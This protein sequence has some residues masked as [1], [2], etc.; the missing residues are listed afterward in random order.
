MLLYMTLNVLHYY[1]IPKEARH[2]VDSEEVVK[3]I[4]RKEYVV[5]GR[6]T[7]YVHLSIGARVELWW[8]R[9]ANEW[10]IRNATKSRMK[11]F[12]KYKEVK[13]G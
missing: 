6:F 5:D 7:Y 1:K 3:V 2:L 9:D 13:K 11:R 4:R 8:D 10:V 12:R